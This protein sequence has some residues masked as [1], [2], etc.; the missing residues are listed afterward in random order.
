[1]AVTST[2]TSHTPSPGTL[3]EVGSPRSNLEPVRAAWALSHPLLTQYYDTEW[4]MPVTDE[5]GVFERLSLEGFQAGLSW[6]TV[7]QKREAFRRAFASFEVDRVAEFDEADIARLLTDSGIIK[8]RQKII[9]TVN[10]ARATRELR[11]SGRHLGEV[12]WD[13]MPEHSPAPVT[14]DEVPAT[15][16]ESHAMAKYL[17]SLGFTFVGPTTLYALMAA[18]GIVDVHLVGSHRRGCSGLWHVDG[19]RRAHR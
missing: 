15:S 16:A 14:D 6:L 11:A 8:N 3:E 9:A 4:G 5:T 12:V 18:I 10:N 1:M 17:K 2:P 13:F 19:T 7:L